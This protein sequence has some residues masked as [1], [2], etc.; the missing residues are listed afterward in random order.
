MSN[1]QFFRPSVSAPKYLCVCLCV[2]DTWVTGT[3]TAE[4]IKTLFGMQIY[5]GTGYKPSPWGQDFPWE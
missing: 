2:F 1:T 4:P 5:L 3:K